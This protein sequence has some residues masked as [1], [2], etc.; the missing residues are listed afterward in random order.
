MKN[1]NLLR[2][3]VNNADAVVQA[4]LGSV[5]HIKDGAA[6]VCADA[7]NTTLRG[8]RREAIRIAQTTYTAKAKDLTRKTLLENAKVSH[9]LGR[10]NITD[11]R[12]MNLINFQA[13]PKRPGPKRP[14]EGASVKVLR[15]GSRK[16]PRS[17][18][19]KAFVMKGLN[20]NVILVVRHRPGKGGIES[21]YGPHPIR[22]LARKGN[23]DLLEELTRAVLPGNLSDAVDK[24]LNASLKQMARRR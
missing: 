16:N 23:Q 24:V 7:I 2:V 1:P 11:H 18:K 10:M 13:S 12:G 4:M 22:A 19:Q 8:V 14:K 3:S 5:A 17:Q 15:G 21:L 9:L 6:R 20:D